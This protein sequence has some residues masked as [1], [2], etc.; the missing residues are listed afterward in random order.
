[1]LV[2]GRV[3][4]LYV[5]VST[6]T[7]SVGDANVGAEYFFTRGFGAGLRFAYTKLRVEETTDP[8]LKVTYRY[9]GLQI[10]GVFALF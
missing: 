1:M 10:Y 2:S 5:S 4:G 3:G 9:S 7:A 6:I 8:L